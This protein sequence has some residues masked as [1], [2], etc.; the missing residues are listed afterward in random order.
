MSVALDAEAEVVGIGMNLAQSNARLE[1][2]SDR[3]TTVHK[4]DPK[5]FSGDG[6][7]LVYSI[8]PISPIAG[9][10][11]RLRLAPGQP[12]SAA[13]EVVGL[14]IRDGGERGAVAR[15]RAD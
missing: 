3:Q 7:R 2:A 1:I 11:F 4:P 13:A 6:A 14:T 5:H 12:D 8:L 15:Y 9:R 10:E